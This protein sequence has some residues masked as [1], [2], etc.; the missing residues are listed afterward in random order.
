MLDN[1]EVQTIKE[2]LKQNV[3][4]LNTFEDVDA[5]LYYCINNK[6]CVFDTVILKNYFINSAQ[7][8]VINCNSSYEKFLEDLENYFD[9]T[10]VFNN[11]KSCCDL[12]ILNIVD[13]TNNLRIE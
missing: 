8:P 4:H 1:S 10:T 13:K 11:I 9:E 5:M 3:I 12:N 6:Y 7:R 2:K